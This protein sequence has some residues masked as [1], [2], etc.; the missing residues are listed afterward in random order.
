M[1][2]IWAKGKSRD[3]GRLDLSA[4]DEGKIIPVGS[5]KRIKYAELP[6]F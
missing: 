6:G 4:F 1:T 2:L 3:I 5:N